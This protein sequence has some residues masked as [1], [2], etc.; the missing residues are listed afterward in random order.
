M[1]GTEQVAMTAAVANVVAAFEHGETL[2]KKIKEKRSR[3]GA[4]LPPPTLEQSLVRGP[5]AI[6]EAYETGWETYGD[7]FR[8]EHD[9]SYYALILVGVHSDKMSR[10]CTR[11]V[12]GHSRQSSKYALPAFIHRAGR[13]YDE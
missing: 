1:A 6:R 9:R 11:G 3:E 8:V 7:A 5:R 12:Q 2:V 13:R 4:L 10:Y